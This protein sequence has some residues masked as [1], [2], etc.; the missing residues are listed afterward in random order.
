[1]CAKGPR[2][3][4]AR[5]ASRACAGW[6]Q[7]AKHV[8]QRIR[9]GQE[10]LPI[11]ACRVRRQGCVRCPA[12]PGRQVG[13]EQCGR[14]ACNR[15]ANTQLPRPGCILPATCLLPK[16]GG[17]T[18]NHQEN[19][20]IGPI[21][22]DKT[23]QKRKDK[24]RPDQTRHCSIAKFQSSP[25]VNTKTTRLSLF[26]PCWPSPNQPASLEV[27]VIVA[28]R[29]RH[30]I[31]LLPSRPVEFFLKAS[32]FTTGSHTVSTTHTACTSPSSTIHVPRRQEQAKHLSTSTAHSYIQ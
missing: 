6:V 10:G 8:N 27:D 4:N 14:L 22:Q 23:R 16:F 28:V 13:R 12:S 32:L 20:S 1:M 21:K 30:P 11:D 19:K 29:S 5:V 24:A 18:S 17:A 2:R 7:F 31:S 9:S 25:P 3:A 26:V 15:P